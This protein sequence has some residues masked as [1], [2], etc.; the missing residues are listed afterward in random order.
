MFKK[1]FC[2]A[3]A[4]AIAGAIAGASS[5][6]AWGDNGHAA[7]GLLMQRLVNPEVR[8]TLE[9]LLNNDSSVNGSFALAGSWADHIKSNSSYNWANSLHYVGLTGTT[10]DTCTAYVPSQCADDRCVITGIANYTERAVAQ[11]PEADRQEAVKFL[12]HFLGDIAQPL[13]ATVVELGGNGNIC[14]WEGE[15]TNLHYVWD[16]SIIDKTINGDF[17]GY[18]NQLEYDIVKGKY[19][20]STASWVSCFGKENASLASC[21]VEW[22]NEANQFDCNYIFPTY[23]AAE[24]R[25]DLELSSKYY[26]DN[27]ENVNRFVARAGVRTAHYFNVL[28]K[29]AC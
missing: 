4:G 10:P 3:L 17:D 25:D 5:A 24:K 12:L 8:S 29:D 28:F 20:S 13:H 14:Y 6:L 23:Y 22:I 11:A 18:V 19:A 15:E 1:A 2:L 21:V 7:V 16:I 26:A 27:A 9:Q